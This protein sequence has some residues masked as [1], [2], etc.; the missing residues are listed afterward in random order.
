MSD[1]LATKNKR[2]PRKNEKYSQEWQESETEYSLIRSI[3][4]ARKSRHMT[5]KELAEARAKQMNVNQTT[6]AAAD[7]GFAWKSIDWKKCEAQV[8]KL[9]ERIVK[10]GPLSL[11]LKTNR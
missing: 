1:L 6:C 11:P 4:A 9:Q 2:V 10:Q 8:K 5:Q 3:A 7:H